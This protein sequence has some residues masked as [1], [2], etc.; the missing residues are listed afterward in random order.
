M[1]VSLQKSLTIEDSHVI[2]KSQLARHIG[3]T[4]TIVTDPSLLLDTR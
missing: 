4:I 2:V 1:L 3:R